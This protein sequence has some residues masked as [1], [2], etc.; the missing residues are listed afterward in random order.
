MTE[1]NERI[2]WSPQS[3]PQ[4]MLV[5]CPITLIGYGG[6]RGGGKTDGVLGKFAVNQE[7]LGEAFNAIFF[8]KELPQADDLIERAKQIYLPL[9]AHWQD[10]KKQ[11]T[12]PNGA[13]LRFRPLADDADAEKY[14]GQN[15]SHAAIEEAGNFSSPSP[16]FKMFGALRGR[17]GGQVILTFNPGGVGHHWLKELFIKPAPMGK[18]ILTKAL[19]NGS[20]FDYIY[21]PSRIADNKILLAQDPEYINRLHMVGSPE[22]VRAWLEGDFEI[23]EGSYFPEFSSRHIIPPFNIPK[24]WPRYLGYD[25]GFRSPFAAVWGAVSSGRDD[26]GNEVPYP[27]GAMVIYREMHG[28]GI[29]NVQQAERIASVSVGENVHAA[30]DPSIFNNQGGPSIADQFHTVFAKYKHPNFRQADNDRL[31]GWSQIRQRLVAKPSLLYITTNCPYLIETLPSLA[32]DKRRPED[33]D[34]SGED[35]ACL[36]G[37][38]LVITD[39]GLLPIKDLCGNFSVRVLS[40]DGQ[41]HDACGA[42]TCKS[43]EVL[44]LHFTD[45]SKITCT[46]DHRFMLADGTWKEAAFLTSSDLIRCVTYESNNNQQYMSGILWSKILPLRKV[47]QFANKIHSWIKTT[48]QSCMA[49][50]QWNNS[51]RF[52]CPSQGRESCKQSNREFNAITSFGSCKTSHDSRTQRAGKKGCNCTCNT[53]SEVLAQISTGQGMALRTCNTN[54]C[55]NANNRQ[56]MRVLWHYIQNKKAHGLEGKVLSP[57]LQN[58]SETKKIESI[59]YSK[60]TQ[61]VYCLNVPQTSTFVLGNGLVSHNCDALRYL[62][63][64]RLVDSKWEQPAEVFN[65]GVIKLQAYIAQMRSQR[66]RATI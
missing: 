34:T 27:K 8:R 49:L 17:G 38:T 22:L 64:E 31:S 25:W 50:F 45:E 12:F 53:N 11:F 41:Y 1:A 40:H 66:G 9:R 24:H 30:A 48:A 10:Q 23:H 65:K 46:P 14:Q 19:P 20:S 3:G 47:F 52:S 35:H 2:V 44:T 5:A 55:S 62:C 13:R 37:D 15:L 26:K 60:A 56:S 54:S 36:T 57:K 29:D 16:I 21:I 18:K 33:V 39:S 61:E 7:Q 58:V 6:A 4:E 28:K 32:I 51:K 43:A 63:K 59:S 42:L